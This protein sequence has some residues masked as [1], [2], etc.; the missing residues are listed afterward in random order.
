MLLTEI[1]DAFLMR[2]QR[3]SKQLNQKVDVINDAEIAWYI[4]AAQQDIQRRLSVVESSVDI[5]L[6]T[7]TNAYA[8]PATFGKQKHA[9][10]GSNILEEKPI[11]WAEKQEVSS[12]DGYWYAIK[13]TGHVPYVYCPISSGTL[14]VVYYPDLSYYQPSLGASQV[15]GSFSGTAY[16]GNAI[17]PNRYSVAIIYNMLS[18]IFPDYLSLYEKELKSLRESRQFSV[19]DTINYNLGGLEDEATYEVSSTTTTTTISSL[20]DAVKRIRIRIDDT[21]AYTVAFSSGWTT[22]PTVV[23]NI[24]TIVVSSADSEFV[25]WVQPAVNNHDFGWTQT[26]A[27][28]ITF[29]AV[30]TSGWGEAEIIINVYD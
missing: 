25:N 29:D 14:T 6:G 22:T 30:P 4:S 7:T 11:V 23:N 20:D 21:G 13:V 27:T 15:W 18:Q 2:Y 1:R 9:Y 16:S 8:L 17:L 10:I 26:G 3:I 28:T 19:E 12:S 5:T 24:S